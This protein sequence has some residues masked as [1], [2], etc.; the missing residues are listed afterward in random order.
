MV[1]GTQL[2]IKFFAGVQGG[3]D[4]TTQTLFGAAKR[5]AEGD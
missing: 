4:R 2:C 3:V 5:L 1:S